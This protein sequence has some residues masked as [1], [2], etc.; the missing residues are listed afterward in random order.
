MARRLS[1]FAIFAAAIAI[2]GCRPSAPTQ[3]SKPNRPAET[4]SLAGHRDAT[5]APAVRITSTTQIQDHVNQRVELEG[6]VQP[7]G[8]GFPR[9]RLDDRDDVLVT[10]VDKNW[11][12][13]VVGRRVRVCGIYTE[14]APS[15][16]RDENEP[17]AQAY[18]NGV[19]FVKNCDWGLAE[20]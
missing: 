20:P 4:T 7:L 8:K 18:A 14:L 15:P 1:T 6:V 13:S 17:V 5:S 11:H 2:V 19:N 12:K 10:F 9:I 16:K 3:P